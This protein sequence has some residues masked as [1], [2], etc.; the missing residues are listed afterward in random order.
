MDKITFIKRLDVESDLKPSCH[1]CGHSTDGVF[2]INENEWV[3]MECLTRKEWE[4]I[5]DNIGSDVQ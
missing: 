1:R 3:C 2:V 5:V 4:I